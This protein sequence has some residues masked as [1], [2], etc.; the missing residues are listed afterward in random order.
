MGAGQ[1][2]NAGVKSFED[3]M[4]LMTNPP[5]HAEEKAQGVENAVCFGR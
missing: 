5:A 3:T 4:K 2:E 1:L